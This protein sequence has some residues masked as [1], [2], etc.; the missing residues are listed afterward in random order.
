M[1]ERPELRIAAE[2][3]FEADPWANYQPP[4]DHE[5]PREYNNMH[6]QKKGRFTVGTFADIQPRTSTWLVDGVL[7]DED[8]T[9][10]IGEEGIAKVLFFRRCNHPSHQSWAQR[11]NHCHRRRF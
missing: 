3:G 4:T 11:V 8:L 10:F 2:Y 5:T 1:T 7:P 6:A 9:V